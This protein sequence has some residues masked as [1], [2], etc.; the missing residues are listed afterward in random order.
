MELRKDYFLNRWVIIAS[1]RE[2]RPKQFQQ[3]HKAQEGVCFFCPGNEHLTPP[4]IGRIPQNGQWKFRWFPN[5]FPAV[6]REGNSKIQTHND[7]YTFAS[8]VGDHQVLVETPDHDKQLWD[9][10]QEDITQI[11]GL[12]R[13]RINVLS[14][15]AHYVVLFKNHG[16]DAGTS[17]VHSH[18]QIMSLN[19]VPTTIAEE[20]LHSKEKCHYCE[21]IQREKNSE[22]RCFENET[23]IA[24]TPYASR[25]KLEAWIFPKNHHKD[26]NSFSDQEQ[27]DMAE[28]LHLT[29]SK[30]KSINAPYNYYLHYSP[31]DE[32]LHFHIE[33]IPRLA[34]WAGFE[35]A[36]GTVINTL[37][38]EDAAI[39]YRT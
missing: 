4:E 3:H 7:Y 19:T 12:Y 20:C 1:G 37:S 22:R 6:T 15:N 13:D 35:Y 21:I 30:L 9:L 11:L 24:F 29:L 16:R 26:L 39:F 36:S 27:K 38:P 33:L 31:K 10:P 25:F 17:L 5:K 18:T 8:A 2:K 14:K 28:M 34:L 23:C 32:N